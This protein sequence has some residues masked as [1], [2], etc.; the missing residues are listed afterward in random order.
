M[1]EEEEEWATGWEEEVSWEEEEEEV[2]WAEE[3]EAVEAVSWEEDQVEEEGCST[4]APQ[5][6]PLRDQSEREE[7]EDTRHPQSGASAS[8]AT[9][10]PG[11][12]IRSRVDQEGELRKDYG[13]LTPSWSAIFPWTATGRR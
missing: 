7:E 3:E 10:G 4:P 5:E 12:V 8:A 6:D 2:S 11:P 1:E 9:T 13:L